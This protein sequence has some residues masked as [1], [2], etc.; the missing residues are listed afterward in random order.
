MNFARFLDANKL[1]S[2]LLAPEPDLRATFIT[3]LLSEGVSLAKVMAIVGHDEVF[4]NN[5]YLRLPELT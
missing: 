4:T 5:E 1:R 3:N 2:K